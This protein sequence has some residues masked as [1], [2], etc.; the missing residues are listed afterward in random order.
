MTKEEEINDPAS[1]LNRAKPGEMIFVLRA[2]DPCAAA[3][4]RIW[5]TLRNLIGKNT[6]PDTDK[7]LKCAHTMDEQRKTGI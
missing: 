3:T 4:V 7:A 1:C 5:V 2:H 6:Y